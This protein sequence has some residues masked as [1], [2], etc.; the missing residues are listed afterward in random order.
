MN[1][2]E[3]LYE[4][5]EKSSSYYQNKIYIAWAMQDFTWFSDCAF[6]VWW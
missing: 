1:S 5:V 6:S 4:P 2:K 3:G